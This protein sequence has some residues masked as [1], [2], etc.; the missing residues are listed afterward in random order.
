MHFEPLAEPIEFSLGSQRAGCPIH[1]CVFFPWHTTVHHHNGPQNKAPW[2]DIGVG[3]SSH[4]RIIPS[5][6]RRTSAIL[7]QRLSNL[8]PRNYVAPLCYENGTDSYWVDINYAANELAKAA[9]RRESAM[10]V[11]VIKLPSAGSAGRSLY[12]LDLW[13]CDLGLGRSHPRI[14][15][16]TIEICHSHQLKFFFSK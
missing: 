8:K 11:L 3:N 4:G 15:H 14:L 12:Y 13:A 16:I 7:H 6:F 2:H 10:K 5:L 9:E 1:S